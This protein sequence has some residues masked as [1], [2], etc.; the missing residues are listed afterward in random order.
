M[1][2]HVGDAT[3]TS[4]I[5]RENCRADR[6]H[7]LLIRLPAGGRNPSRRPAIFR[8]KRLRFSA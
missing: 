5:S 7:G 6:N 2:E 8:M 4:S 1:L 3:E